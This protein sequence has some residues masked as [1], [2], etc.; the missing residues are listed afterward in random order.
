MLTFIAPTPRRTSGEFSPDLQENKNRCKLLCSHCAVLTSA[1]ATM[2][3]HQL[4][5][6]LLRK[7]HICSVFLRTTVAHKRILKLSFA[8]VAKSRKHVKLNRSVTYP[9]FLCIY[10]YMWDLRF[11]RKTKRHLSGNFFFARPVSY[12]NGGLFSCFV[13]FL[14]KNIGINSEKCME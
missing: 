11:I 1:T 2:H 3:L 4:R 6:K 9:E 10:L 7:V 14:V 8:S 5:D 12:K 13:R